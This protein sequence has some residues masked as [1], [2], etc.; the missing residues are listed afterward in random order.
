MLARKLSW[1]LGFSVALLCGTGCGTYKV[2]F[3]LSEVI[4]AYGDDQTRQALDV[5]IV[6]LSGSE[7]DKYPE[8]I[9]K[10]LTSDEWFKLR[11]ETSARLANIDPS[12]IYALRAGQKSS[13]DQL[14][15]PPLTGSADRADKAKSVTFTV[16]HPGYTNGKSAIVIYGRFSS[17]EGVAKTAPIVLQ[18]PPQWAKGNEIRIRVDRNGMQLVET[19]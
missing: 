1:L 9:N 3:E 11:R 5:D 6:C 15:G 10:T 19:H 16:K 4:N 8:I 7:S 13:N 2:T 12:H 14:L 18:P 17:R